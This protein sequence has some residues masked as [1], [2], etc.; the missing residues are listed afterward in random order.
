MELFFFFTLLITLLSPLSSAFS[1]EKNTGS[2]VRRAFLSSSMVAG[3]QFAFAQSDAAEDFQRIP[4]QFIAALGDPK[5]NSGS[6]AKQWGIWRKDPGPRGV[7]LDRYTQDIAKR[8]NTAPVGW[9][10]NPND[11]W[12]EEHGLIME[13]PDFPLPPGRYLV[14][15]G[16]EV[17]T[18]LNVDP[19]GNWK[20]GDNAKLYDVTHL[21]CRSARYT[22]VSGGSPLTANKEDF[23][24]K[25]GSEMPKVDGCDKQDYAVLFVVGIDKSK[26]IQ[27]L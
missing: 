4:T 1:N 7:W 26:Q 16:R 9:K 25:P 20:L 21:P 8:D 22:P 17:T 19:N 2:L 27:E 23:P 6:E 13:R 18:S 11:W 24:V 3:A 15:G 12:L 5:A 10:F 14:T